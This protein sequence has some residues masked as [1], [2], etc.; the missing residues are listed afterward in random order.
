MPQTMRVVVVGAG[1]V[2]LAA[3]RAVLNGDPD[4][5]VVVL[6]KEF[7]VGRH[8]TGHNS[9]VVHAGLYYKP[10]SLKAR[11]CRRGVGLLR[12]YCLTRGL[13]YEECGK[14]VVATDERELGRLNDIH[15][16]AGAN[17]VPGITR[18]SESELRAIEPHVRGVA[19]L[20][21]PSTAIVD[22]GAVASSLRDELIDLGASLRLGVAVSSIASGSSTAEVFLADGN[23]DRA[24]RVLVC[25]GLQADRLA[26]A[27]GRSPDPCI[28]PF[29]GQYYALRPGRES[30]VNGLIY[31]V[32]DPALPFLGIHLTK[33]IGGGVLVGPNAVLALAR[34]G[35]TRTS[36]SRA[37]VRDIVRWPGMRALAR[38]HWRAG[39]DELARSVNRRLFVKEGRRYV[40]ELSSADVL[41]ARPGIRAQAVSATGRL[42]DD[43]VLDTDRNVVWV[44]NAPSPGATS[45][46]AIA[47]ELA[48]HL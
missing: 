1:I 47:E 16:R 20:H 35:Y 6:D 14:L 19:G 11:L 9:G 32:P 7:E 23:V 45:S 10:G 36:V 5:D 28:I 26:R 12:D 29:R 39:L 4:A 18:V 8:Q 31:P 22:F 43:F 21:S 41:P 24:D 30:L 46:L 3:A 17:G 48:Q 13:Q 34:E 33:R 38:K 27:S 2:G 44:R 40:P 15:E 42:V 25:A 37:D